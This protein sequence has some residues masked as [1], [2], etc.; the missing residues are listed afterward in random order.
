MSISKIMAIVLLVSLVSAWSAA[1]AQPAASGPESST[2]SASQAAAMPAPI[3][4]QGGSLAFTSELGRIN[5]IRGGLSLA[6]T[7]DDNTLNTSTDPVSDVTY[8]VW[9]TIAFDQSRG[10][11]KWTLDYA[12]GLTIDQRLSARNQGSHAAG[13]KA[14]FRVSPH[15]TFRL[16]D[17]FTDTTSFFTDVN[18]TTDAP[19]GGVLQHPN[20]SLVTPLARQIGNFTSA[21]G[22]YQFGAGSI[23]GGSGSYYFS[24]FSDPDSGTGSASGLLEDTRSEQAQGFYTHRLTPKNWAG[25]TYRFQRLTFGSGVNETL[26]H[27]ILYFHTIYLNP[28]MTLSVFGGPEYV[29]SSSQTIN[30]IIQLPLILMVATPVDHQAW[31]GSG[32]ATFAWQGRHTSASVDAVRRISDGGGLLGAVRTNSLDASLRRQLNRFSSF[33]VG[34]GYATNDAVDFTAAPGSSIRGISGRVTFEQRLI[35][36]LVLRLGYAR[37]NQRQSSTGATPADIDHNRAWVSL[38]YNFSRPWGR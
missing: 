16:L 37:D 8:S 38:A 6:S 17:R 31:S 29:D 21:E 4:G 20:Q 19:A 28:T 15:V 23:V 10:R 33:E 13:L 1:Q 36:N 9:P 26:S 3:T 7:F 27:S 35:N 24:R 14:D 22:E 32:G 34:G 12:G 30:P 25:V 11:L 18:G 2:D 5:Y